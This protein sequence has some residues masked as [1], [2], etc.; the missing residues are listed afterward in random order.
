MTVEY[1]KLVDWKIYLEREI[2][3]FIFSIFIDSYGNSLKNII[4]IGIEHQLNQYKDNKGIF[5]KSKTELKKLEQYFSTLID[6]NDE[7]I[8]YWLGREEEIYNNLNQLK[9][10]KTVQ[11][12]IN[13]FKEAIIHNTII[14]YW[15]LIGLKSS[16]KEHKELQKRLEKVRLRSAYPIL[17]EK[18]IYPLFELVAKKLNISN[19]LVPLLTNKELIKILKDE[20]TITKKEL[21]RRK[22]GCYFY[23]L[24][25]EFIFVYDKLTFLGEENYYSKNIIKGETAFKGKVIGK[26]KIVNNSM[27]LSKFD[28]GDI[29]VSINL[30]PSLMPIIGKAS[31]IIT[32]EGGIMCHAAILSREMGIPCIVGTNIASKVLKDGDFVEVN[33]NA[34]GGRIKILK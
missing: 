26:V 30:N 29:I 8:N 7:R 10:L 31:A 20:I 4:G 15:L 6:N 27:N 14:P 18:L 24:N 3:L 23:L 13:F 12:K 16:K 22:S 33:A 32:N 34:D 17:L 5:Y 2:D 1:L 9:K 11:E 28:N 19:D 21:E 25:D